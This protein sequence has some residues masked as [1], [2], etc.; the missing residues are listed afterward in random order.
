MARQ[1]SQADRDRF[2]TERRDQLERLQSQIAGKVTDLVNGAEWQQWLSV[3]AKFHQYSFNNTMLIMLQRPEATLVAGYK[4]WQTSFGRQV[5]KGETGIRIL[6]P[7]TKRIE[8][9]TGDGAP[10]LDNDGNPV[11]VTALVGLKPVSVFDVL[12]RVLLRD[13]RLGSCARFCSFLGVQASLA[14]HWLCFCFECLGGVCVEEFGPSDDGSDAVDLEF[15]G[16]E[17]AFGF[18]VA[19]SVVEGFGV[20]GE[21]GSEGIE[22]ATLGLDVAAAEADESAGAVFARGQD[23]D[24]GAHVPQGVGEGELV[25]VGGGG[26]DR[27]FVA[28]DVEVHAAHGSAV[29]VDEFVGVEL[30]V[31][32]DGVDGGVP[33][34]RLDDVDR[35]VGVE[36]FG[37]E[38]AP[39]VVGR[40]VEWAAV[41]SGCAGVGGD[42]VKR[43]R[44]DAAPV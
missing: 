26:R 17:L 24:V 32:H 15:P 1:Y 44:F 40:Q 23:A 14:G 5:N 13:S 7:V 35:G 2:A 30:G 36:V 3:A 37:S 28:V 20:A 25:P 9:H 39:A 33:E 27:R 42:P 34:E 19:A 16:G 12:S 29:L 22:C 6:A 43:P 8:K 41:G 18:V 11:K 31:D 4:T 10:V 38:Q 21:H